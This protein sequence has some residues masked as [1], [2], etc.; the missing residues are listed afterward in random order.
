MLRTL[1]PTVFYDFGRADIAI[2]PLF[3]TGKIHVPR[4]LQ[5]RLAPAMPTRK[6]SYLKDNKNIRHGTIVYVGQPWDWE[7]EERYLFRAGAVPG[8]RDYRFGH[9]QVQRH[10]QQLCE[11]DKHSHSSTQN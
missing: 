4:Y 7:P 8:V 2:G 10:R 3:C 11:M 6:Y 5:F 1:L 9:S